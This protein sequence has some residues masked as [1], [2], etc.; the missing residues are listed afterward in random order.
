MAYWI[1]K[2]EPSTYSFDNLLKDGKAVWDGVRNPQALI[3]IRSMIKGDLA[4]IYHSGDGKCIVGIAQ[5]AGNPY[6]DP[7]LKD[8][9]LVVVDLIPKG[10]VSKQVTLAEIKA[11]PKLADLKLVRQSRLSVV[12]VPQAM[13]TEMMKMAGEK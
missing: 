4:F 9:K 10:A 11:N 5:I 6:P 2:T 13:W 12:P 1:L 8:P 7:K 3:H